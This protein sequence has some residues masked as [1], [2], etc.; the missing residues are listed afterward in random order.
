[1]NGDFTTDLYRRLLSDPGIETALAN[2][3]RAQIEVRSGTNLPGWAGFQ[4]FIR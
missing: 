1:M 2:S 3:K 4:L